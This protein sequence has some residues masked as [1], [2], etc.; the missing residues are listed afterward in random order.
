M[1]ASTYHVHP[2]SDSWLQASG[3]GPVM[4]VSSLHKK[5]LLELSKH[6]LV[7]RWSSLAS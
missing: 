3:K 2:T 5:R 1:D 6:F 7:E 4:S